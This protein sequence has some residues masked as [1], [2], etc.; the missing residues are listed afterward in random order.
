MRRGRVYRT[1]SCFDFSPTDKNVNGRKR[2][3]VLKKRSIILSMKTIFFGG[4]FDP[5]HNEHRA[6][7]EGA[8]KEVSADRVVI[9]PS[10]YPPHKESLASPFE[11]RFEMVTEGTKDLR[12]V[13]VDPIEKER[14]T[15]NY[16]YEVIPLLKRKYPSDEYFFL[17]GGDSMAHFFGWKN[18]EIIAREIKILVAGRADIPDL[19]EAVERARKEYAA[20]IAVL[21]VEGK[22]VSSSVIKARAELGLPQKDV[23]EGVERI[24]KQNG[25]YLSYASIVDRL[26]DNI[27]QKTFE[28]ACRT[29]LY[30]L[31]L[32]TSLNLPY[33]KVFL[34]ALLHDCAKHIKTEIEGVPAPVT[35]QYTGA[36][37]AR[38]QYGVDDADVISAIRCHTTGKPD[39]TALE[40]LIFCAD[41]LEEGRDYPGV[42]ELR[43]IIES[44]FEKGFRACVKSC[45]EHLLAGGGSF[46]LLTKA[47]AVYYNIIK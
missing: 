21:R 12:Y 15:T 17:I 14:N 39:M 43:K 9:Y 32:N 8:Q 24:I 35:H 4:A 37:V 25:L 34:S 30:A 27:P 47:C 18:P 19:N 41:V 3:F 6:I 13:I 45:Y 42:K 40:K 31:K 20:D 16:S 23:C 10:Y 33:K 7:V 38:T 28:H 5:F 46:D 1:F 11:T 22:S 36:D 2:L 26:R 29:V 44:D